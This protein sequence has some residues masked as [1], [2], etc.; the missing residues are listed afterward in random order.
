MFAFT[1]SLDHGDARRTLATLIKPHLSP[2]LFKNRI[3]RLERLNSAYLACSAPPWPAPGLCVT[4]EIHYQS[5]LWLPLDGLR[6]HFYHLYRRALAYPPILS[7]T[8]FTD[9]P[10]WAGLVAG[11]PSFL[12]QSANP[13]E[14]LGLLQSD[15]ELRTKFLFWS[16]M[17][18]RFYGDGGDRY[19]R[20]TVMIAEWLRRRPHSNRRLRCLDA[21]SGDGAGTYGVARLLLELGWTPDRFEIEGWTLEPLEAWAAAHSVFPHDPLREVGF[22]RWCLPVFEQKAQHS[23]LFRARNLDHDIPSQDNSATCH[24]FE[25]IICNGLLGGPIINRPDEMRRIVSQLGRMLT[26]GGLLLA[27]DHFHGGWKQKCPQQELRA[28]FEMNG[29]TAVAAEEGIAAISR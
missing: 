6:P 9:H 8:P 11:F 21:A 27:A 22:R 28:L 18:E 5:E 1:P 14:L 23:V 15:D 29:L 3:Q 19:P 25:L 10:S 4:P 24:K 16:F 20:Q 26:P 12:S 7:S 17:P 13:A 2:L